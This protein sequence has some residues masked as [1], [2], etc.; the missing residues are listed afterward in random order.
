MQ[1]L[2][3]LY[4]TDVLFY[5]KQNTWYMQPQTICILYSTMQH[6]DIHPFCISKRQSPTEDGFSHSQMKCTIYH[7]FLCCTSLYTHYCV[8][9]GLCKTPNSCWLASIYGKYWFMGTLCKLCEEG[10]TMA[11]TYLLTQIL[12]PSSISVTVHIYFTE[13]HKQKVLFLPG[14]KFHKNRNTEPLDWIPPFPHCIFF[15]LSMA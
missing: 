1:N 9:A 4:I 12:H 11:W 5:I 3:Q 10:L 13:L 2:F 6:S 15:F 8:L 14:L 7:V